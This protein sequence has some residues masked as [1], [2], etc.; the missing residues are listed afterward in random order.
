MHKIYFYYLRS[1]EPFE[2]QFQQKKNENKASVDDGSTKRNQQS[3][4]AIKMSSKKY[5]EDNKNIPNK[6]DDLSFNLMLFI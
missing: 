5:Q 4:F 1:K 2:I 6:Q 3:I